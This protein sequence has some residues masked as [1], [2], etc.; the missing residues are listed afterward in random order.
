MIKRR[1]RTSDDD[2]SPST[3]TSTLARSSR[4]SAVCQRFEFDAPRF[5]DFCHTPYRRRLVLLEAMLLNNHANANDN[6]NDNDDN[7]ETL[8]ESPLTATPPDI[9]WFQRGPHAGHERSTPGTPPTPLITP[10]ALLMRRVGLGS[11]GRIV[12][13][14]S[15]GSGNNSGGGGGSGREKNGG[16]HGTQLLDHN[17]NNNRP[18]HSSLHSPL[19][20]TVTMMS[21]LRV[22]TSPLSD[23]LSRSPS[24]P[25]LAHD[26]TELDNEESVLTDDDDDDR[27]DELIVASQPRIINHNIRS[28]AVLCPPPHRLPQVRKRGPAAMD[29]VR[30]NTQRGRGVQLNDIKRLLSE[31]NSRVRPGKR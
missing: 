29:L 16:E 21:P 9:D 31:H 24:P 3:T 25:S 15:S 23:N 11:P 12:K 8:P 17:N 2:S 4:A 14:G 18:S 7:L 5:H 30:V 6:D 1:R 26:L 22:Q 13:N 19:R 10:T 20:K 27:D 28:T